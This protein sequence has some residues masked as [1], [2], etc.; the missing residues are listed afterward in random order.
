MVT[1]LFSRK[2]P[3]H[4]YR[5]VVYVNIYNGSVNSWKYIKSFIKEKVV[6]IYIQVYHSLCISLWLGKLI[7]LIICHPKWKIYLGGWFFIL[8]FYLFFF[9]CSFLFVLFS[10]LYFFRGVFFALFCLLFV[11]RLCVVRSFN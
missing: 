5:R 2:F 8:F 4:L 7:Y 6:K 1:F 10:V 11:L 3:H 9:F